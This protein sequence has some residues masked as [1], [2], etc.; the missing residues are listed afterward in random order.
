MSEADERKQEDRERNLRDNGRT[1]EKRADGA[2]LVAEEEEEQLGREGVSDNDL[3][4]PK[5]IDVANGLNGER[6]D[7]LHRLH[8]VRECESLH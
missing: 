4:I 2:D 5:V 8:F 7:A 6:R 3:S 1:G